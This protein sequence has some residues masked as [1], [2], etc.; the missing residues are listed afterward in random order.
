MA[1]PIHFGSYDE[2]N[3]SNLECAEDIVNYTNNKNNTNKISKCLSEN[4]I[5]RKFSAEGEDNNNNNN[6]YN[7]SILKNKNGD[8]LHLA[9][10]EEEYNL[11]HKILYDKN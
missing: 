10:Q 9:I 1:T 7:G 8:N 2:I 6:E 3:D 11:S 4:T 5:F